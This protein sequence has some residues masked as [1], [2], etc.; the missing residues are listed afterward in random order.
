MDIEHRVTVICNAITDIGVPFDRAAGED[1]LARWN[2]RRGVLQAQL[3]Q[4]FPGTNL[5]SRP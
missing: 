2:A 4:Q 5:N 3:A 1:L